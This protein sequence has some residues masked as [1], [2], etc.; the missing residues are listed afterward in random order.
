MAYVS[1]I[2]HVFQFL[3]RLEQKKRFSLVFC[4]ERVIGDA[5]P[6]LHLFFFWNYI[7]AQKKFSWRDL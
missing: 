1:M 4:L 2:K 5:P 6:H 3:R 7:I